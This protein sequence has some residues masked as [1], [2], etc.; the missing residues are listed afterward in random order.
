MVRRILDALAFSSLWVAAAATSLAAAASRS[1]GAAPRPAL[2]AFV[3][4]GTLAVYAV[5]RLRDVARDRLTTPARSAWVER[6][7]S[8]V[9]GIAA[10]AAL[11]AGL[12][13]LA[14]G[15]VAIPTAALAGGL[16]AFH[17]RL[18]HVPFAKA[19][20]VSA[21]W[22]AVTV[23]LPAALANPRPSPAALGRAAAT[24]GLALLAN[25]IA[26]SARD[27]EAG[28]ALIG[29][30]RALR[31]A[32]G[33]ALAG[34]AAGLLAPRPQRALASVAIATAAAL[35]AFRPGERY[36]LLVLDGAL[37]LGALWSLG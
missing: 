37:A 27:V 3:F 14:L 31:L 15:R 21:A 19:L 6:H 18:K 7:R 13:G 33:C 35:L 8:G 22:V 17:R 2:L 5:D 28:A 20:Y 12:C 30:K 26:S 16:G 36:G 9:A 4:G 11:V 24:L 25:A 29:R 1:F 34:S 23:A 10:I 32:L